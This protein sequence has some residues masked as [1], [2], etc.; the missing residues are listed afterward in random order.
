[1]YVGAYVWN[2][3]ALSIQD[4]KLARYATE[5]KLYGNGL[6]DDVAELN[7]VFRGIYC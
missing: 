3:V 4:Y 2:S 6:H 1:M 7:P 5:F